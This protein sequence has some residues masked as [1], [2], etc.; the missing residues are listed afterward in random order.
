M[1][2]AALLTLAGLCL[3]VAFSGL[4]A[5][6]LQRG[7]L[8]EGLGLG[9][10][11][12]A[13]IGMIALP[14]VKTFAERALTL[15]MPTLLVMLLSLPP[16]FYH[17]V[18]AKT[19]RAPT[20][21]I[22]WRDLALPILGGVVCL[23]YWSLPSEARAVMI[24]DGELPPGVLPTVLALATFGLIMIWL[25]VS[26]A[27]LVAIVRRLTAYRVEIRQ[28]YSDAE[29]R[30]LRWVNVVIVLLVLI[31]AAGAFSLA[32]DNLANS[33]LLITE[34]VLVLIAVGLLV[35]NIFAPIAPPNLELD[36]REIDPDPK[37]ARSALTSDHVA[38]LADRLETAMRKES[39][40]LDP[41]LSL[42]KLSKQVGALP[43]HVSQTLNQEIGATIFDYVSRWRI[44][45][46]KPLITAGEASV[47]S[48]AMDVGYNSR[49]AFYK[50]FKRETGMRPRD[51]RN[52][53]QT[54]TVSH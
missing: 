7:G 21:H 8:R 9:L 18:T 49:S 1:T 42:Q 38:K 24:I 12:V 19:G 47:L 48:V 27:Y 34:L 17:F 2:N 29:E 50:A 10:V 36:M 46:S 39:L 33:T 40:Y 53:Q 6:L 45:A 37:Y 4:L 22:P 26:F 31:W 14:V 51:F 52:A 44:E 43:N 15:Y 25:I 30:D 41:N 23:G 5:V 32:E 11:Y 35:L 16:A 3:G 20:S 54:A 28:F 13:F